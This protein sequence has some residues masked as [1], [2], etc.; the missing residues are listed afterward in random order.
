M[1]HFKGLKGDL[2]V[3]WDGTGARSDLYI[4]D[5]KKRAKV[6]EIDGVDDEDLKWLTPMTV[7]VWVTQA[8]AERAVAAGCPDTLPGNPAE[9]DSLMTLDLEKLVVRPAGRYR[10]TV[11]Q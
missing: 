8:Y 10:C 6:L 5:L 2:L 9:M 4:Y 11:G 1:Q 7:G 3:A